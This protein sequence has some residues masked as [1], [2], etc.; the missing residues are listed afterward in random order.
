MAHRGRGIRAPTPP[1]GVALE[2]PRPPRSRR[3]GPLKCA[4]VTAA[5]RRPPCH[6]WPS[7]VGKKRKEFVMVNGSLRNASGKAARVAVA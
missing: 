6:A 1:C 4:R 7:R 5:L 3:I 2:C